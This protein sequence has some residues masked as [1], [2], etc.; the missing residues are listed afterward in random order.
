MTA[1]LHKLLCYVHIKFMRT[2]LVISYLC[3]HLLE[4][5]SLNMKGVRNIAEKWNIN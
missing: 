1:V 2:Y 5:S 3:T 4:L